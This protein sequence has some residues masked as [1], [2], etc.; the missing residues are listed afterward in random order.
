MKFSLGDD[1]DAQARGT[2]EYLRRISGIDPSKARSKFKRHI[3]G[4]IG[5][6][7]KEI[8][9][10]VKKAVEDLTKQGIHCEAVKREFRSF[11]RVTML[12]LRLFL[13]PKNKMKKH[14]IFS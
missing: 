14:L 10:E 5:D 13:N 8:T 7:S 1:S 6:L 2:I 12:M 4:A 9:S 3:A 11:W